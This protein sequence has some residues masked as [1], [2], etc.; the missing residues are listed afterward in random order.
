VEAVEEF[1]AG[2]A[3][4][5]ATELLATRFGVLALFEDGVASFGVEPVAEAWRYEISGPLQGASVS[6]DGETVMLRHGADIGPVSRQRTAALDAGSGSVVDAY[7]TWGEAPSEG[8]LLRDV[9]V[10]ADREGVLSAH[11]FSGDSDAWE[12]DLSES[13]SSG[14]IDEVDLEPAETQLLA[15]YTCV[16]DGSAHLEGISA[17]SG[18]VSWNYAWED[19]SAPRIHLLEEHSVPGTSGDPI[20]RMLD[21]GLS[22]AFAFFAAGDPSSDPLHPEPWRSVPG[23]ADYVDAPLQDLH[24]APREI[25]VHTS[26]PNTLHDRLL[27]QVAR[28]LAEDD[29]V[30][31]SKDDIDE[32]LLID[33]ELVENTRQWQTGADGYVGALRDELEAAFPTAGDGRGWTGAVS[34]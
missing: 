17:D 3:R 2:D 5:P 27:V 12:R 21:E 29:G 33:G 20:V 11:P 25:V 23:I 13:C 4:G 8:L 10:T 7:D 18:T 34:P 26:T 16:D 9:W 32:S 15:S 30:P 14:G 22:G 1:L 24:T 31:F 19:A 6:W 28:W